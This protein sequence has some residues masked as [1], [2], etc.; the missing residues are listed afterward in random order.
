M[1]ARRSS[2]RRSKR[3]PRPRTFVAPPNEACWIETDSYDRGAFSRLR[4]ESPALADVLENGERLVPRF[5][6]L[7][8]DLFALCF[9]NNIVF[10][11]PDAV[12]PSAHPHRALLA[13]LADSSALQ[14]LR[15]HTP[16][17]EAR[18]GLGAVLL[19]DEL[20]AQI[21]GGRLW[22]RGDLRDLW[23]LAAE[24]AEARQ[25]IETYAGAQELAERD[26]G[27][28]SAAPGDRA[29]DKGNRLARTVAD[30]ER[31]A[32]VAEATL[33]QKARRGE[34]FLNV[35]VGYLKVRHDRI[36]KDPDQRVR[37]ALGL[38]FRKFAEFQSIR[39][40]HLWLR[41]EQVLLPSVE[42]VEDGRRIVWKP[43][44]YNTVHHLLTNPVYGGA[45]AFGRT[46]SG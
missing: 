16:L 31:E 19:A 11:L 22:N 4:D 1:A 40:V 12:A 28:E 26:Q 34:L 14:A 8:E 25:K 7:V 10:R 33:R 3:R 17:D 18:A 9:K 20:L 46:T 32:A 39:Q 6:P 27:A 29:D 41:Q 37:E 42:T 38:V 45:Y 5:A 43:P 35:A 21:R 36:T 15:L 13:A 24:E 44:V 30:L 2:P 23:D